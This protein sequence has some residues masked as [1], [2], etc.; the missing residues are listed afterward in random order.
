MK[1][2]QL[3]DIHV[4]PESTCRCWWM[5][6]D[7]QT[8]LHRSI[9]MLNRIPDLDF[10]VLTGD[11]V[12]GAD[13]WSFE[14]LKSQLGQLN[15]PYWASIGNHDFD[16]E[17]RRGKLTRPD[18]IAWC[19]S[20]FSFELAPT[21]YVDYVA[22]PR[23]GF[24]IIGLD[25][26][27]GRF[28]Q[29]QGRIR[30]PQLDWLEQVLATHA[31]DGIL[32]LIHQP[33]VASVLFRKYRVLP[34][35]SAALQRVLRSHR[36]IVGVLSG[37]LHVPKV[38]RRQGIPYLTSPPLVGPVSAFRVFE[39]EEKSERALSMRYDWHFVSTPAQAARPLWHGVMMGGRRDRRG[40]FQILKPAHW[41][42]SIALEQVI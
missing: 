3:S 20:Q 24:K 28:P 41:T 6:D 25:A 15:V 42:D 29:P 10:V 19:E 34:E 27:S 37:H 13:P 17:G 8:L 38:Y 35:E 33:P 14:Q 2:A 16:S 32:V 30:P 7:A 11:L 31:Q 12:D 18:F 21:G 23:P 1:F 5:P 36:H 4:M 40:Q 39:I 9:E 22:A 26:S